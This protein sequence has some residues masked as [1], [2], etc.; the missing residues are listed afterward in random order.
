MDKNNVKIMYYK[1]FFMYKPMG[2]DIPEIQKGLKKT[3]ISLE[4]LAYGLSNG[5]TFKPAILSGTKNVSWKNQQLFALDFD[6]NTT[7]EEE[8]KRCDK[9]DLQPVFGYITFSHTESV[10][11]FRLVFCFNKP[12]TDVRIRDYVQN[13]LLKTFKYADQKCLDKTRLF[14]G[15]TDLIAENY[16]A[17]ISLDHSLF[18]TECCKSS[19][20]SKSSDNL[21][22]QAIQKLDVS[23]MKTLLSEN[24]SHIVRNNLN[25]REGFSLPSL[26]NKNKTIYL[27]KKEL[28][29]FLN[30]IDLSVYLNVSINKLFRCI[31]PE[32]D[33][34]K[35]SAHIYKTYD[36]TQIY[37]CFGCEASLGILKLTAHLAKCSEK[38]AKQFLLDI[39]NIQLKESDWIVQQKSVLKQ[40]IELLQSTLI[41]SKYPNLGKIIRS[42]KIYLIMTLQYYYDYI[43]EE[44]QCNGAPVFY[45]SYNKLKEIWEISSKRSNSDISKSL[46]LFSLL[47]M[48]KKLKEEEIPEYF[49]KIAKGISSRYN[50]GKINTYFSI[51]EYNEEFLLNCEQIADKLK[52]SHFTLSGLSR[53]YILRTFGIDKAD[54][55]FP[56]LNRENQYGTS[57]RSDFK[58][59]KIV[60]HIEQEINSNGFVF[61]KNLN[62]T[63]GIQWKRSIDEILNIYC[64]KRVCTNKE[65]KKRFNIETSGHPYII[66]RDENYI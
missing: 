63:F 46:T 15:G 19:R 6:G 37:K 55:L 21:N 8:L 25:N 12:I 28:S 66:I 43:E 65:F 40:N 58:T 57:S 45:T 22:V 32:H 7:I 10:H 16:S 41:E 9:L 50:Y 4:E 17:R 44:L 33:D 31:L 27:N 2:D 54:E 3:E 39:F 52:E 26:V 18:K 24:P 53:E 36:G 11:K 60:E 59:E 49:L 61:E 14:F 29:D 42:R 35:P 56:Q 30:N 48:L 34:A 62:K 20:Y 47:G 13:Q 23:Q 64:L 38:R 1:K 51:P 5:A